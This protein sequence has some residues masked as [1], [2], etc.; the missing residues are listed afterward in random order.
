MIIIICHHCLLKIGTSRFVCPLMP[1]QKK[2]KLLLL[3]LFH[4]SLDSE[5]FYPHSHPSPYLCFCL[6]ISE[7]DFGFVYFVWGWGGG[8]SGSGGFNGGPSEWGFSICL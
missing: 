1:M 4:K 7:V 6:S 8:S 5:I 3:I 2:N